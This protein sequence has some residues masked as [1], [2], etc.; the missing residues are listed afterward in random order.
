M[1]ASHLIH[2]TGLV[3]LALTVFGLV[4]SNDRALRKTTGIAS[5][6]W[7]INNLLMG[8]HTAAALNAISIGR[9]ASAEVVQSRSSRTRLLAFLF[10]VAIS[11][12]ASSLTWEGWTSVYTAAGSLVGT[13]AM[14]YLRGAALR[15]AMVLVAVL[16][17][18]NAWAYNSWWQMV[19]IF[20][21]GSAALF[22]AWRARETAASTAN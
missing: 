11:L 10:I 15:L 1:N 3:A 20:A 18:Y 2:I 8:A 5:A 7:A 22:G 4:G 6:I 21:S 16:W 12:I 17:M 19:G 9:Q 13:W 14:F